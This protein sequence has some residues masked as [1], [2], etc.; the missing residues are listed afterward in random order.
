M[1]YIVDDDPSV[2]TAVTR[3]MRS[4]GYPAR[5]FANAEEYLGH[6]DD[7]QTAARCV[8]LDLH[9]PGMTGVDLQEVIN[10][11]EP[12]VPVVI[13]TGSDDTELCARAVAAG[14]AKVVRKPCDS[15]VLLR[16][17]A[18]AI[19]KSSPPSL[20]FARPPAYTTPPSGEF[21]GGGNG[22]GDPD[23][24]VLE[25]GHAR[26]RPA[27]PFSFDEAVRLVRSAIAAARRHRVPA[28]LV[29]T[30]AL[31][32]FQSPDT[33]ERFLAVVAWAEEARAGVRLAMVARAEMIHP[34]KF[35]VLVAGNKRLVSNIFTTE[36]EARAWLAA[37]DGE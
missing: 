24:F 8:I 34:Q 22:S 36:D 10:A 2:R 12:A 33:Y 27:G 6:A 20:P 13:L 9:L 1:L 15:M 29:N 30:T 7:A 5:A 32:G 17:V 14:A 25:E 35:G 18:D 19:E 37:W 3:L 26:Y 21:C 23:N 28:L 4:A 11:R 16:A 31:T